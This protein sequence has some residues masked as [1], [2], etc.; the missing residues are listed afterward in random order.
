MRVNGLIPKMSNPL[1]EVQAVLNDLEDDLGKTKT[2]WE[3]LRVSNPDF[4]QLSEKHWEEKSSR[5][6][7]HGATAVTEAIELEQRIFDSPPVSKTA[8]APASKIH[9]AWKRWLEEKGEWGAYYCDAAQF[10]IPLP[11]QGETLIDFII[12]LAHLVEESGKGDRLGWRALKSF[13]DFTRK[14]H[15][16]EEVAFIEHIFPKK[17]RLFHSRIIR[18]ISPETYPIPE[19]AAANILIELARRCRTGRPDAQLT[20]AECLG[21]CWICLTASRLRLPVHLEVIQKIKPISIQSGPILQVPTW[22][23]DRPVKIS[24]RIEKFLKT[25]ANLPSKTPRETI[26]Q[27]PLRSLSRAFEH[28]LQ[29]VPPNP[30]YGNITIASLLSQ[31]HIFGDHRYQPNELKFK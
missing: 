9:R 19:E 24:H 16:I 8:Q 12:R 11:K 1:Q 23:G 27:R 3:N 17:M 26:L 10:R 18:L 31:P 6:W 2:I 4:E 21:L 29:T 14:K 5:C 20:A 13:L 22:F 25:L 30:N 7:L 28:T 15:S